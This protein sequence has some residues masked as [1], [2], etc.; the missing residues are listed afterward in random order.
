MSSAEVCVHASYESTVRLLPA[1]SPSSSSCS[2]FSQVTS[3]RF[4]VAWQ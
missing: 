4:L 1:G 2:V 3:C